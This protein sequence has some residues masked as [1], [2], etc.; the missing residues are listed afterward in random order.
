[1]IHILDDTLKFPPVEEAEIDGLL[2][3]GGDLSPER[4]MVAYRNGIFP[5]FNEPPILWWCP[6]PRCVIFPNEMKISKSM[7]PYLNQNK[8]TFKYNTA[9]KEVM[10]GC[11]DVERREEGTWISDE[12]IQSYSTLYDMGYGLSAEAWDGDQLVGGLYGLKIGK[13]FFGESM[14]SKSP[15][16]SK[17]AF[18]K[19]NE[20]FKE[21]GILL[22]DCQI[23]NPHLA[24]L[25]A[26]MI[27]RRRFFSI[28][29]EG[30]KNTD[31]I[32]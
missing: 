28:L 4:L 6:D 8:Y 22:I 24:T 14:F 19:M 26:R 7:R 17:F 1:M 5:W 21:W 12:I 3:V 18:I 29:E 16:A 25:G 15:N 27:P 20:L 13:I 31:P 23:Y 9:F 11:R 10:K 32:K 2:A 30:L